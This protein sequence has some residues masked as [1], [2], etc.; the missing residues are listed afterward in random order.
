MLGFY[1]LVLIL[2]CM[3]AYAGYENTMNVFAYLDVQM[4]YRCLLL[5]TYPMRR[6]LESDLNLPPTSIIKHVFPEE[7]KND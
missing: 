2:V 1:F 3:I 6:K 7:Q 4:R 5:R